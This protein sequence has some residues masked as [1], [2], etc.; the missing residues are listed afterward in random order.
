M[1]AAK[2][3]FISAGALVAGRFIRVTDLQRQTRKEGG[4]KDVIYVTE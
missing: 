4:R 1:E 2:I 3:S